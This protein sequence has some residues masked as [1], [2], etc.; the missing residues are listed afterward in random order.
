[1]NNY[2]MSN[3]VIMNWWFLSFAYYK[4]IFY[5]RMYYEFV[6]IKNANLFKIQ[7]EYN[8]F[9]KVFFLDKSQNSPPS[10]FNE[11]YE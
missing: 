10:F 2:I 6:T 5:Y 9:Y 8:T 7:C 4:F 1:M 3:L 11:K